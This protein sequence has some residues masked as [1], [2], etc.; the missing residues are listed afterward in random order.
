MHIKK[1]AVIGAGTMGSQIAHCLSL[2][3]IPVNLM[4]LD[5]AVVQRGL[6]AIRKIY[7]TSV[8]KGKITAAEMSQKMALISVGADYDALKDAD[9]VVEAVFEEMDVKREV[10]S[11]LDAA[12]SPR[13]LLASNT[14]SLS[15]SALGAMT[16]RPEK[17]IG[18]H[19]FNPVYAMKLVE[20]VPGLATAP[21]TVSAVIE[22]SKIV[23]KVPIR[24]S[25]CP[26]FVVNRLLMPYLNEALFA[27]QEGAASP[28]EVDDAM[29]AFGMPMGPY[30][31]LDM[32]GIDV[33]E[34]VSYVLYDAF[35]LRMPVAALLTE[36]V[37][38]NR[39][40]RKSGAG[41]YHYDGKKEEGLPKIIQQIQKYTGRTGTLFSPERLLLFMINE[42]AIGLQEGAATA[43]D[44]DLAMI[45]GTGFP[46]DK[47][48]PLHYADQV[49]LDLVLEELQRYVRDL[50]PRFWPAP[51]L[52]RMVG[53]GY[54][55]VKAKR[56]FFTY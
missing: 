32:I 20:V 35:G 10:F 50:G 16:R 46:Q 31:L 24:V 56:G 43:E 33:A 17:V 44:I 52:K 15:I 11:S 18:M 21:Q 37:K 54:T 1:A 7:Q 45:L 25:E 34:R 12:C 48:G 47:G 23:R 14:S 22:L 53:A 8:E 38:E 19:F 13:A 6:E 26:G 28:K 9:I 3:G 41:I 27:L 55:G 51:I 36:L 4:D 2:A 39:L 40:G 49:G 42:A 30:E 5:E 29:K